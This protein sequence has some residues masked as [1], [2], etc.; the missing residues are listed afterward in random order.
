MLVLLQ[1]AE[2]VPRLFFPFGSIPEAELHAWLEQIGLTF[3]ADLVEL[4]RLAG[5]GD[6]FETET[7]FRP[8]VPSAPNS[9][10]VEDA[11]EERNFGHA[12]DGKPGGLYIFQEGGFSRQ[13]D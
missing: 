9:G 8:T 6:V 5:G 10:F 2:C 3:P 4:W 11:I 1:D 13:F 12:S 7:I